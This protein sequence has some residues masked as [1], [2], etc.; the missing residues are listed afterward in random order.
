MTTKRIPLKKV[1]LAPYNPRITLTP[2]DQ[3]WK[4]IEASLNE[5]GYLGGMVVN[6][7][8]MNLVAGHQRLAIL[9]ARGETSVEFA[10]VDLD[11]ASERRLNIVMNRVSG[12]WDDSKLAD[13]LSHLQSQQL[14]ISSLGFSP[15]QI[16]DLL[17][18]AKPKPK[19]DPDAPAPPVTIAQTKPGDLYEL[20]TGDGSTRH[21][22]L[23]G[24]STRAD[25]M[26]KLMG[27]EKARLVFVDPPYGV[28]YES[29]ETARGAHP[30]YQGAIAND[31][32]RAGNLI[33]FLAQAFERLHEAT[34]DKAA[35]YCF[36]ASC[37]H[38]EF[39]TAMMESGWRVKQELVW[40]KQMALSRSDFHW[41]HEPILYGAK[42]GQNC[43]W[44]G[45]RTET[46]LFD[47]GEPPDLD[48]MSKDELRDMLKAIV[49]HSTVW[50]EKR[51]SANLYL[52]PTQ[53]PTNLCRRALRNSSL[54]GEIV[55]DS[56]GGS[57]SSL[58]AAELEG[59]QARLCE[60]D[61]CYVDAT[62][63]RFDDTFEAVHIS[64]N[65]KIYQ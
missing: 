47:S 50:N 60:L 42:T 15:T 35:L 17:T 2:E 9:R 1:K 36:F 25:H 31:N 26:A 33:R 27:K 63:K 54:P 12:R 37:N 16:Q 11:D 22:V 10:T 13:I 40:A 23:C 62:V 56:F 6:T 44:L 4:D 30:G 45:D 38:I 21:R 39:E 53:K 32:L 19:Q 29:A 65:G 28:S 18:K 58:I 34:I 59:R 14:D 41:A 61:P 49:E 24:D 46:T 8:T 55:L 43:E 51:D 57:G 52:H 64:L 20:F 7:R 5:F 48:C 3:E